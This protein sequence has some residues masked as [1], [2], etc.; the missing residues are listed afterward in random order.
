MN[1]ASLKKRHEIREH[2]KLQIPNKKKKKKK[3]QTNKQ[4]DKLG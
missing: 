4:R 1:C 3:K 2:G